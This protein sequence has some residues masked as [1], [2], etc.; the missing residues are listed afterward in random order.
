[1]Q[2]ICDESTLLAA[3]PLATRLSPRLRC[4]DGER[5]SGDRLRQFVRRA[6]GDQYAVI[7]D[8]QPMAAF[9]FV[10]VVGG[11]EDRR[12]CVGKLE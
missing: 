1:V 11:N 7:E 3:L 9:G 4:P 12:P 6:V 10:H 5:A 2:L 8:R